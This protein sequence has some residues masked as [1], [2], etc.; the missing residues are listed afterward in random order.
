M[1]RYMFIGAFDT[2]GYKPGK[3]YVLHTWFAPW[4]GEMCIWVSLPDGRRRCP[5]TSIE[6]FLGNWD[7]L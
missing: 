2:L 6:N 4:H 3:E 1:T 5:Y 7:K